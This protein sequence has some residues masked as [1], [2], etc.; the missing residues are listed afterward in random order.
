MSEVGETVATPAET[1]GASA[2]SGDTQ[3]AEAGETGPAAQGADGETG[4][5]GTRGEM[6][7]TANAAEPGQSEFA[8]EAG[9]P[10]ESDEG[11]AGDALARSGA[12]AYEPFQD[13]QPEPGVDSP[14]EQASQAHGET[15]NHSEGVEASPETTVE[16]AEPG[17][18][19]PGETGPETPRETGEATDETGEPADESGEA[20]DEPREAV[21]AEESAEAPDEPGETEPEDSGGDDSA[22][23]LGE[24]DPG[25]DNGSVSDVE[26]GEGEPA[27]VG[28]SARGAGSNAEQHAAT[29][30]RAGA[31]S[32]EDGGDRSRLGYADVSARH[33]DSYV[34]S[35]A[36]PPSVEGPH[37]SPETWAGDVNQPGMDAPGRDNNCAECARATQ[38]TWAGEPATAAAMADPNAGEPTAR[39]TEFAGA[40]PESASMDQVADRLTELGPGSSAIVGFDRGPGELG[41]WFNAV[42]DGGTIKAVDGQSGLTE[43][44]PPSEDGLGFDE[45]EMT[46]SD[47][48]YFGPDGKVA[49]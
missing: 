37:A 25:G 12:A 28:T 27:A 33:P 5:A 44:W 32:H 15:S 29:G 35:E 24:A 11:T 1:Q 41:H 14:A 23:Q 10:S 16:P 6:G 49:K 20:T 21:E 45:S 2:E 36:S 9:T 38:S 47:A 22:D 3:V 30:T 17:G 42:N 4:E 39:M 34:E 46:A 43:A 18:K 7:E 13:G 40:S 26:P 48:I 8:D 19:N 31:S